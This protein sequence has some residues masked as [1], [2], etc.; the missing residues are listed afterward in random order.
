ME[1]YL[2]FDQPETPLQHCNMYTR[3]TENKYLINE[4]GK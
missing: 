1:L 3:N 4:K 2:Q